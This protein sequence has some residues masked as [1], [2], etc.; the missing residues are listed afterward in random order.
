LYDEPASNDSMLANMSGV[1]RLALTAPG[2]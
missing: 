2:P 1:R